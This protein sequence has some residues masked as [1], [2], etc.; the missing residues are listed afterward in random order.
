MAASALARFG[1]PPDAVV[2][3]AVE[4][5]LVSLQAGVDADEER[6]GMA[7][8]LTCLV[9]DGATTALGH[10][11]DSRA[12]LW[13]A[14]TLVRI[15]RDHTYV[16]QLVEDGAMSAEEALVHPWRHV[17]MRS[18][19]S[20]ADVPPESVAPDVVLLDLQPG[21][22]LLLC[23]DGV[24]DLVPERRIAEVLRLGMPGAAAAVLVQHALE[25]GG[26]DNAT[27][28]VLDVEEG[29]RVVGTGTALGA[30]ADLA[31]IVD[32]ASV[33]LEEAGERP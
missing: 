22:R 13:R 18:L 9:T 14:Q 25:A 6:Q 23:S 29:P 27:A 20:S 33:H 2:R 21:D 32:P 4:A 5:A 1:T 7:T 15:T 10:V 12:Y 8:T 31:N 28:V 16:Q 3:D 11:G 26:R 19:H 17:V 30:L 24:S